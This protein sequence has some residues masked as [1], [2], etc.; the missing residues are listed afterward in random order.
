MGKLRQERFSFILEEEE[1]EEG[2]AAANHDIEKEKGGS[3]SLGRDMFSSV[4][5][6]TSS[7]K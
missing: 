6:I 4:L 2:E 7:S 5:S 3:K 1:Q